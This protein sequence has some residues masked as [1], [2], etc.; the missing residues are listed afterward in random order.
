MDEELRK[1]IRSAR[2]LP[3]PPVITVRLIEMC[4]DP[5]A[6]VKDVID[7]IG[8]DAALA[9]RLMR[10]AN[11][12][13]YAR[14]RRT[15]NLRQAVML[16]GF[17]VVLTASLSLVVAADRRVKEARSADFRMKRWTRSVHGAAASQLLAERVPRVNAND[18]FLAALVQDIGIQVIDRLEPE[19]YA[20]CDPHGEHDALIVV[21]RDRFGVDHAE[22]GAEML[23][24]WRLPT[25]IVEAVRSSHDPAASRLPLLAAAVAAGGL[26]ADGVA[27]DMDGFDRAAELCGGVLG[28]SEQEFA[29]SLSYLA[30]VLPDFAA[31]LDADVPDPELL[32]EVAEDA[33]LAR[34][35][36]AQS[37]A[38]E[39]KTQVADLTHA[40]EELRTQNE[41]DSLTGLAN[42]RKLDEVMA[43]EFA[44]ATEHKVPLSLLFVDLDDFKRVN[45]R[46]GHKV[47]DE[48]LIQSA[49]RISASVRNGDLVG[50][51]GG[52]EFVVVLPGADR[53]NAD[54]VAGRLIERFN[55][56]PFELNGGAAL[57][58]TVSVG[59]ATMGPTDDY[60]EVAELVHVADLALY[61]AK[62][63]GK[64]QW[65]RGE[66]PTAPLS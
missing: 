35:T 29:E 26:I 32:A 1:R 47:G 11:S 48:L 54:D 39:L 43:E 10:L 28:L 55:G 12:P 44:V 45:D 21:E 30:E 23:D 17:D 64:N 20:P 51:F 2:S 19:L 66:A 60:A 65:Q 50:R 37:T 8:T 18:A 62:R 42:R 31:V 7:L 40:A 15:E 9:A 3:S 24:A 6:S 27:G 22:V 63:R 61:N 59:V 5:D 36:R 41:L 46:F 4:E 56:N 14:R 52:E 13:L 25:D 38:A 33:V 49:R 34:Q 16:L 57:A 58:Q 53:A